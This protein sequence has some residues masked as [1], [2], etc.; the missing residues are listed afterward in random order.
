M[1]GVQTCALPIY[2][3]AERLPS[4][5]TVQVSQADVKSLTQA[6]TA[7]KLSLALVGSDWAEKR[8]PDGLPAI[9]LPEPEEA[10][11][12]VADAP[13]PP[14]QEVEQCFTYVT[15]GV[16]REAIPRPCDE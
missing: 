15:R 5:V 9:T 14:P 6:Q 3:A 8:T 1:T 2:R 16:E 4:T 7:G 12:I 10:P 13:P 11:V